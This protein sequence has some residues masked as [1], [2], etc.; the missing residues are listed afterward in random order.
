MVFKASQEHK[1]VANMM[2]DCLVKDV[3]VCIE[4]SRQKHAWKRNSECH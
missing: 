4:L 3:G 2:Y 1:R